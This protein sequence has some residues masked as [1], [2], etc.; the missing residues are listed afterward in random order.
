MAAFD[1]ALLAANIANYNLLPLSSVIPPGCEIE[2]KRPDTHPDEYGHRLYVVM[3]HQI[4]DEPGEE[5]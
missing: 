3:A 5:A 4:V 2:Q 1:A